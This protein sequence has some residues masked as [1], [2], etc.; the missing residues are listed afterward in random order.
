MRMTSRAEKAGAHS[1][2]PHRRSSS[3]PSRRVAL[4]ANAEIGAIRDSL[5]T[6]SIRYSGILVGCASVAVPLPE[7]SKLAQKQKNVVTLVAQ[8]LARGSGGSPACRHKETQTKQNGLP[9]TPTPSF[10]ERASSPSHTFSY[11]QSTPFCSSTY[12]S[13]AA[14][15]SVRPSPALP[16]PNPT[17]R[18]SPGFF[19]ARF[20]HA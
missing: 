10:V 3:S 9:L 8:S 6:L 4:V 19:L 12:R 20:H 17:S 14:R 15:P 1:R 13:G 5:H 18:S 11:F 2:G 7:A 16:S